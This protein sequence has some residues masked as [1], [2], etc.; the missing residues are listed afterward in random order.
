MTDRTADRTMRAIVQTGF[1]GP[2][3]LGLQRVPRPEPVP[4]EVLVR[5]RAAGI[6]PVD[7]KTREGL[8]AAAALATPPLVPGWDVAGVV[9]EVGVGVTVLKP[10]DEV[11]GMP[12]FPRA[13]GAY[14]EYVTA[15]ARQFARKPDGLSF[16]QAAALP[17][18]ALTA[19]QALVDTAALRRGERLLVHAGSGGVGHLAVQLAHHLGAQVLTTASASR[20][21]WLR[22]LGAD[23]V[24]DYRTT[25]FEDVVSGV[26]TVLDLVGAQGDTSARSLGVLRP[27]GLLVVVPS[28]GSGDIHERAAEA[29][30]RSTGILVE[31]DGTSLA[32]I[33]ALVEEG[34]LRVHVDD[35]YPLEEAA[36]AH[37]RAEAG[38][39]RG[40]L[41]LSV[42]EH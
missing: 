28:S 42:A 15:P 7:R 19:W 25:R 21:A 24:L 36:A 26:D 41:V 39:T 33:A 20:H 12:W 31:P 27:G 10:G 34:A 17:L 4:T 37:A 23:E 6:N 18:A 40:K 22:S 11:F 35:V 32:R 3:V 38:G 29:G 5:V 2:E 13:A 16:E 30:L 14:A 8:G 9:E 1:G